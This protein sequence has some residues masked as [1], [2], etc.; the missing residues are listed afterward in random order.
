MIPRL[1]LLLALLS[2]AWT[3]TPVRELKLYKTYGDSAEIFDQTVDVA[4]ITNGVGRFL[5]TTVDRC[6]ERAAKEGRSAQSI[7]SMRG[8][9]S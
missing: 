9:W 2:L 5:Q 3:N 7:A 6:A 4:V 1:T 8:L